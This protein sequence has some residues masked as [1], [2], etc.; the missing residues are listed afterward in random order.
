MLVFDVHPQW[1]HN[2]LR[3]YLYPNDLIHQQQVEYR[4]FYYIKLFHM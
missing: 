1:L 4:R 3:L 2:I